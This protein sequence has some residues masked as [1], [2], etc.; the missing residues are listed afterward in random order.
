MEKAEE[1]LVKVENDDSA[2]KNDIKKQKNICDAK[3]RVFDTL[4][5]EYGRQLCEANRV[6][7]LY[8][9][10][11]LPA[12]FDT[13]QALETRRIETFQSL[14]NECT[15]IEIE[16]LPRIQQCLRE[17]EATAQAIRPEQDTEICVNLYKTGYQV[18]IITIVI[19]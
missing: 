10:E 6:K 18:C 15:S 5:A 4:E 11:Q 1:A 19:S 14:V 9:Y 13:L 3:K 8:Y 2:S 17:I 7:N 12:V 16:V